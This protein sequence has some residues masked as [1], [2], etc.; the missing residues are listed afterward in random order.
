MSRCALNMIRD[1]CRNQIYLLTVTHLA[2]G[3]PSFT[4]KTRHT[5][6]ALFCLGSCV[7]F[8]HLLDL[9]YFCS[10]SWFD[11]TYVQ[12]SKP[13]SNFLIG[14]F[15]NQRRRKIT[16]FVQYFVFFTAP[17]SYNAAEWNLANDQAQKQIASG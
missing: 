12:F 6:Y 2:Y 15:T 16:L 1:N 14:I 5:L 9:W 8:V 7:A 17:V 3:L 10:A 13:F 11:L 4:R